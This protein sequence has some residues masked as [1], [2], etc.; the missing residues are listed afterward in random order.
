MHD[1]RG[2]YFT[3][4]TNHFPRRRDCRRYPTKH[5]RTVAPQTTIAAIVPLAPHR[6]Q[7]TPTGR[8]SNDRRLCGYRDDPRLGSLNFVSVAPIV[9]ICEMG[10]P[11]AMVAGSLI[12]LL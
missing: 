3:L 4:L 2:G 11:F 5:V 10:D 7:A 6:Q 8:H 9:A 12:L 1:S